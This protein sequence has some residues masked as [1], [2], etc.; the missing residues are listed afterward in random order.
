MAVN[1]SGVDEVDAAINSA[2]AGG[3]GYVLGDGTPL[4]S[5]DS[6]GSQADP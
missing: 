2:E 5:P 6:P 3:D 1:G 4:Q